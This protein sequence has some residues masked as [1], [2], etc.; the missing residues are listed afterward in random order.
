[1]HPFLKARR[2]ADSTNPEVAAE[3]QRMVQAHQQAVMTSMEHVA[4]RALEGQ[5]DGAMV[6]IRLGDD[7]MSF[8]YCVNAPGDHVVPDR[9][10]LLLGRPPHGPMI[11]GPINPSASS[12]GT[13]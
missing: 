9:R 4:L 7:G 12:D 2:A 8:V 3:F 11:G 10:F 6:A 1:M 13:S 5:P